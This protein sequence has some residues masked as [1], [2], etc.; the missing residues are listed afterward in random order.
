MTRKLERTRLRNL[1]HLIQEAGT[2]KELARLSGTHSSYLSQVR[3]RTRTAAGTPRRMTDNLAETL[4][5]GMRKPEGWMDEFHELDP[6]D[7]APTVSHSVYGEAQL[8]SLR[9]LISWGQAGAW[10]EISPSYVPGYDAQ[11]LPCPIHCSHRTFVLK[12]CGISMEPRFYEGDLIYV[13][14][15]VE[16]EN[17]K[18]VVALLDDASEAIFKQL[19]VEQ[20]RRYLRALNPNWP[21]AIT[22]IDVT[23]TICGVVVFKGAIV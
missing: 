17:G 12:V 20:G 6:S 10:A 21:E 18:Y 8:R 13:D 9:P 2:L 3:H 16:P 4:E 1:E 19:V 22:E 11:L 14:P 23:G 7:T 5:R 15:E